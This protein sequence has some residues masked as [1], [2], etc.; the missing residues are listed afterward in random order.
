MQPWRYAPQHLPRLL[1]LLCR[2]STLQCG[3]SRHQPILGFDREGTGVFA[4]SGKFLGQAH[5]KFIGGNSTCYRS[6]AISVG[7][8]EWV[9]VCPSTRARHSAEGQVGMSTSTCSPGWGTGFSR[10]ATS[11]SY[12]NIGKFDR[13]RLDMASTGSPSTHVQG[14]SLRPSGRHTNTLD[15]DLPHVATLGNVCTN[16]LHGRSAWNGHHSGLPFRTRPAPRPAAHDVRGLQLHPSTRTS[17]SPSSTVRRLSL[18]ATARA[19]RASGSAPHRRPA[20]RAG[21]HDQH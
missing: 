13:A 6:Y 16:G 3:R 5:T 9:D 18:H 15:S 17:T 7:S 14:P 11:T 2:A 12:K 4:G 20:Q 1:E 21:A 8:A 10:A 19:T